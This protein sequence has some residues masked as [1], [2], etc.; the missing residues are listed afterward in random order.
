VGIAP[1]VGAEKSQT[2][3]PPKRINWLGEIGRRAGLIRL[4][5]ICPQDSGEE[6][7]SSTSPFS[8]GSGCCV[9]DKPR[10]GEGV[11]MTDDHVEVGVW[12]MKR[13]ER[14]RFPLAP[15]K[16]K[17]WHPIAMALCPALRGGLG[18]LVNGFTHCIFFE[19]EEEVPLLL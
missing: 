15:P 12:K 5:I 19:E 9:D 11:S 7:S 17:S 10:E 1:K 18:P 14:Y 6:E 16:I 4:E 13:S 2:F 3:P 8:W